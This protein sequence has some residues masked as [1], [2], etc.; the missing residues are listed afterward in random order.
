MAGT[1]VRDRVQPGVAYGIGYRDAPF[2]A[3]AFRYPG[4]ESE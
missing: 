4:H 3:A 2:L 1:G